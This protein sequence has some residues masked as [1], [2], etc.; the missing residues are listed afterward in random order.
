M[1]LP[2]LQY[3]DPRLARKA[4]PIEEISPRIRE[5]AADMAETMY[6]RDG[7][8][9]AAPQVGEALRLVVLDISGPERREDLRVLVNPVLT[10]SGE[11]LAAD[12]GCLSV[13]E[14]S[15]KVTRREFAAVRAS[16][17]EGRPVVFDASGRLAV[18]VQHECDHLEGVLF[19]DRLSRLKRDMLDRRLKKKAAD[20]AR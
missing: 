14:F 7:V 15:A 13:P 20:H 18:C 17:L 3:P 19:I 16:D 4:V 9:L 2:V 5:L 10:L 12:E 1:I 8:G 11:E 6:A